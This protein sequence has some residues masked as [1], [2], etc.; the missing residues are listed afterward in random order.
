MENQNDIDK[1]IHK[2]YDL[3][4]ILEENLQAL[5]LRNLIDWIDP[6]SLLQEHISFCRYL[7]QSYNNLFK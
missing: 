7:Q 4:G 1:L 6:L 3:C 2:R 5:F